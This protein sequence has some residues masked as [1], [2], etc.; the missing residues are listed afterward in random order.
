MEKNHS[1]SFRCL[2]FFDMSE[3]DAERRTSKR[4]RE[5]IEA[6]RAP[7]SYKEVDEDGSSAALDVDLPRAW[8]RR[9]PEHVYYISLSKDVGVKAE[10]AYLRIGV[11]GIE[12]WDNFWVAKVKKRVRAADVRDGKAK[13]PRMV[14]NADTR[15]LTIEKWGASL[16]FHSQ[17]SFDRAVAFVA[18]HF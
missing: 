9:I 14:F 11:S 4:V 16:V 18:Q 6:G 15:S 5:M 1:V 8:R 13:W 17:R 2:F 3:M 12:F 7:P 10:G